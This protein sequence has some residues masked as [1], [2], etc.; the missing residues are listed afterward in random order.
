VHSMKPETRLTLIAVIIV[1]SAAYAYVIAEHRDVAVA[2]V[3][4]YVPVVL[5]ILVAIHLGKR[6]HDRNPRA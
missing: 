6:N 5:T 3:L 4:W 1:L 2:I